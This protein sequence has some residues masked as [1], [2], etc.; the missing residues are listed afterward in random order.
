MRALLLPLLLA[1][2]CGAAAP[3]PGHWYFES[4][5]SDGRRALLRELDP[6]SRATLHMRV[7]ETASGKVVEDVTMPELGRVP[8]T[9]LGGKATELAELEWMLASPPFARDL[10]QGARVARAFPFGACGRLAAGGTIAFD[11]GDWLYVADEHGRVQRRIADEAAY[12]PRFSPDGKYL[13][14]R[15]ATGSDGLF[16]SY[17][18]FV[19]P[20]D[21]SSPGRVIPGT[22]GLRDRFYANPDGSTAVGVSSRMIGSPPKPE[23]C[24]VSFG[25][26]PPFAARRMACLDGAEQLVE[27]VVSPRGKWAAIS[28]KRHTDDAQRRVLWRLRVVNLATGKVVKDEPETAGL[29]IRAIS[30]AGVL[31]QSE[32]LSTHPIATTIV[33]DVPAMKWRTLEKS[34]DLG[35]RGFFRSDRDLVYVSEGTVASIDVMKD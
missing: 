9:T 20:A 30:D 16:A 24:V 26:K 11:A 10:E 34:V 28:T 19:A 8:A 21:L 2:T 29:G 1:A 17:E 3:P 27:S 14:Y 25:L 35:H 23:T 6:A 4:L 33:T 5:S 13:F 12:D 15:K 18:L 31:V 32:L 22:A 7:V